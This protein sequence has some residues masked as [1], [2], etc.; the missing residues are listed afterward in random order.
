[1]TGISPFDLPIAVPA[2]QVMARSTRASGSNSTFVPTADFANYT[3]GKVCYC[4]TL[5]TGSRG[6]S[7]SI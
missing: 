6:P 2:P 3:K 1:M 5:Y 4:D 7:R